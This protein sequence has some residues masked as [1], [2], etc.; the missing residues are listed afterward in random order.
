[1]GEGYL[2]WAAL[3][4]LPER[5]QRVQTR[6]RMAQTSQVIAVVEAAGGFFV[7]RREIKIVQ[8]GCG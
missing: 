5:R 2:T 4:T 6:I 7:A 8:G 3:V 1:M